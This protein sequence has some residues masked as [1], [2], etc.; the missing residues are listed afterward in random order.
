MCNIF[1]VVKKFLAFFVIAVSAVLLVGCSGVENRTRDYPWEL[2]LVM[3]YRLDSEAIRD[4]AVGGLETFLDGQFT[5]VAGHGEVHHQGNVLQIQLHFDN[6]RAFLLFNGLSATTEILDNVVEVQIDTSLFFLERTMTFQNPWIKIADNMNRTESINNAVAGYANLDATVL[7]EYV[8]VFPST[9]RRTRV[10]GHYQRE[11]NLIEFL[12]Y[13]RADVEDIV[14]FDR[15]PNTPI[16]YV[17]GIGATI[18]FMLVVYMLFRV[19]RKNGQVQSDNV[20]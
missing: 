20:I 9:V 12:Y 1:I 4:G 7:P 17:I 8:F 3:R 2:I 5:G 11:N 19:T 16:W 14:I 15:M 10:E 13:F 6:Y 18:A